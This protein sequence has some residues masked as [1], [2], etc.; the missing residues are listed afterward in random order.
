MPK[1][2][3]AEPEE[4]NVAAMVRDQ[5]ADAHRRRLAAVGLTF[6]R[7][8]R[9]LAERQTVPGMN[10]W[11]GVAGQTHYLGLP[12]TVEP[13]APFRRP[14]ELVLVPGASPEAKAHRDATRDQRARHDHGPAIRTRIERLGDRPTLEV[15]AEGLTRAQL[16]DVISHWCVANP[17]DPI[18]AGL[19][20]VLRANGSFE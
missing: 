20:D 17:A 2:L 6:T 7:T 15:V 4:P 9:E 19:T 14:V 3:Q 18:V 16:C 8:G 1:P 12:F 10:P 5:T 13:D 11:S